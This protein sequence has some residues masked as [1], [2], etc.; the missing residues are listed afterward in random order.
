[1]SLQNG[2]SAPLE[3]IYFKKISFPNP[4]TEFFLP[5][6]ETFG[7]LSSALTL[8]GLTVVLIKSSLEG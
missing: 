8:L 3:K 2:P 1:M 7:L 5:P 6:M 4:V